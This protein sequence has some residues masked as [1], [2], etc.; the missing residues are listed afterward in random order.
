MQRDPIGYKDSMNLY[1]YAFNNPINFIDPF[2]LEVY[3]GQHPAFLN[4]KGNPL[5]HVAIV[6]RPD[7]PSDFANHPLF[8][9]SCGQEATIGGQAFGEGRM[10]LF[11]ALKTEFNYPGDNASKLSDLTLVATPKGMTDTQF[12]ISIIKAANRYDNKSS[13]S[14][15]PFSFSSGYNSNSY[16]SGV[17]TEAGGVPPDLPG[18]QPGYD[19]PLKIK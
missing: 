19:K 5:N 4:K 2:G 7:N 1:Q 15:L 16:V 3:V 18:S 8:K 12:I 10:G 9:G 6:L 14:P 11:G 17:I 13:Y